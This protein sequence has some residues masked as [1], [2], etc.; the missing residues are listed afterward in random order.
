MFAR[1]LL[2]AGEFVTTVPVG[3][4]ITLQYSEKGSIQRIFQWHNK[5]N[6]FD[7]SDEILQIVLRNK[8]VP[9]KI[10]VKGGTTWVRGVFYTPYVFADSGELPYTT[11]DSLMSNYLS[12]PS[13]FQFYA[14]D[15]ESLASTFRGAVPIRQWLSLAGFN[16]LPGWVVP[17]QIDEAVF[18]NMVSKGYPFQYPLIQSYILFHKDG[19]IS[20]PVTGLKQ[21]LTKRVVR[22]LNE[23]G[24]IL[25]KIYDTDDHM[26][27]V[28]YI[29]VVK[30]N[31]NVNTLVV[32]DSDGN[33]IF[34]SETDSVKRDKRSNK[35]E[36]SCCGRQLIVPSSGKYFRCSDN[37]CN[38]VLYPRV[39]QMLSDFS[40]PT[41]SFDKYKQITKKIGTIFSLP[42]VF[43]LE[44]YEDSVIEVTLSKAVRAAIPRSIL[45][46]Q[47]QIDQLCDAAGSLE[48]ISYYIDHVDKMKTDLQLDI[49]A[50]RRFYEWVA[51]PENASDV[52]HILHLKNI[53]YVKTKGRFNGAP[54]FRDKTIMLTGTF[55][56][57]S[58]SEVSGILESYSANVT[59]EFNKDIHC[60]LVG[61]IQENVNG[62]AVIEARRNSIPVMQ[63]S[64]FFLQYDIDADMAENL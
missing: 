64:Q 6:W 9:N 59:I 1:N 8:Q 57:G 33:F 44:E 50:F 22:D 34:S 51:R 21:F 54:I 16:L 4:P 30:Y 20:Y 32:T 15:V 46:N 42:D 31:I 12:D 23:S 19:T 56:H 26:Y 63:E 38:S 58:V 49:H 3:I 47:R 2:Q 60:L 28:S 25:A 10:S 35:I 55:S 39:N 27:T 48:S 61:D 13:E 24:D 29:D 52:Y 62:H 37:Q 43:D 14:G 40:L 17:A 53:Q 41:M 45:P 5:E 11:Q 7:I 18:E 36:C